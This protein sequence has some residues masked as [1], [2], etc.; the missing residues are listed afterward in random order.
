MNLTNCTAAKI[1]VLVPAT[2]DLSLLTQTLESIASARERYLPTGGEVNVYVQSNSE[3]EDLDDSLI[4]FVYNECVDVVRVKSIPEFY[5]KSSGGFIA[6]VDVGTL[7]TDS[8]LTTLAPFLSEAETL[9]AGLF[10]K[11][12]DFLKVMDAQAPLQ[13]DV[14]NALQSGLRKHDWKVV[15]SSSVNHA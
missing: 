1:D 8:I 10:Y 5:E 12:E 3:S 15:R 14:A 4:R 9:E 2:E 13:K 6:L 7:W 11:R